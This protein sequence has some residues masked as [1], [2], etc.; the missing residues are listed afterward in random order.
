MEGV[1][2]EAASLAGHLGLGKL[3]YLYDDNHIT[4]EGPTALAFSEDVGHRFSSY[5]WHVLQVTDGNDFELLHQ[6]VCR[7]KEVL[8][9]P[10]LV[11]VRTRIAYGSPNKEDSADAHGAPL[12][13]EEV[14]LTKRALGWDEEAEFL[15]PEEVRALYRQ[16]AERGATAREAWQAGVAVYE[17]EYPQEAAQFMRAVAGELPEGWAN[18]L[19]VFDPNDKALATR[20]ASG[21][22]LNAIAPLI[23]TLVGGSADLGP[24]NNT[25]LK[26]TDEWLPGTFQR[27]FRGGRNFHFGVREH[28]MG[29]LLNG[30]A[31][32]GGVFPYG[33]TFLVFSDYMRP[34]I[35]LAALSSAH[36]VYVFT[37]DS[38]GLGED[39]PTHQPIE[40]LASLRAIP[41]LV[42][43]R[44][45][46]ANEVSVAW[47][48]ALEEVR[49]PCAL[50][51]TR[52]SVPTFDRA[53]GLG[54][55][56]DLVRGA[57]VMAEAAGEGPDVILIGTGSEVSVAL[58]ARALLA[59][60]GVRARVVAMPSFELFEM[61]Q[62]EYRE[63]VFPP[64]VEARVS[65]E[66]ASTF[67][68]ER[69]VGLKG[70]TV[71]IDRFGA[72]A[73]AERL[74]VEFGI[75]A[76]RVAAEAQVAL[77]GIRG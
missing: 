18:A 23:P 11:M 33:G 19:P 50:V 63:S 31:Q 7:A 53:T 58:E 64:D 71:G 40:H 6:A 32:H 76:E 45:S 35:R 29:G 10:S 62:R 77:A 25:T 65:V 52:Q 42:V 17:Q 20:V 8:D 36:V 39:G 49:G 75:T 69:Y 22:V 14:R 66:A 73:P 59:E 74:Y 44:P 4:I 5:G 21:K 24:S 13:V 1:S 38:I 12:G 72:S 68:W 56:E 41:D 37:H 61:Q 54:P 57:Y 15:V 9:R 47:R 3:V 27:R 34:S 28:G 2:A 46:D 30:M 70:R 43:I 51:L 26:P 60:E 67:G 48:V 55:A 16:A